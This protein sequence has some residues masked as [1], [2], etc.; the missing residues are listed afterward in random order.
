MKLL[1]KKKAVCLISDG[2]DSPVATFLLEKK[3]IEVI[4]LHFNNKPYVGLSKHQKQDKINLE[5]IL[6]KEKKNHSQQIEKICHSL[7]HSFQNQKKFKLYI[8]PHGDDLA[9][10]INKSDD[11]QITCILCKRLMLKKAE[12]FAKQIGATLVMT[13]DILGEQASQTI[14][15]LKIIEDSLTDIRLIRPNIGLNKEE[16]ISIARE[17][18]TYQYSELAAKY[19]CTAVPNKPATKASKERIQLA[20][21]KLN[22]PN[23]IE[24]SWKKALLIAI[25][26]TFE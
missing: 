24:N 15:N 10:I 20:E 4:G 2:L 13:G 25:S 3:G 22:F 23:L 7:V 5:I 16:V 9:E 17:I 12:Y 8:V 6:S 19:T 11:K 21:E 14:D 26:E 1:L 18:G